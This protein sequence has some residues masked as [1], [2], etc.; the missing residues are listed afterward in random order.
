M[1][2]PAIQ[3]ERHRAS[4]I[5]LLRNT[6]LRDVLRGRLT[7][8]LNVEAVLA[9]AS[10]PDSLRSLAR[11]VVR[12]T[13]LWRLEKVDVARELVAHF[14]DGIDAGRSLKN[15]SES[16][17]D[18][19][20]AARLIR[21]AKKRQRPFPV[22]ALALAAQTVCAVLIMLPVTYA[23]LAVY[24]HSGSPRIARNFT[25]VWNAAA[26]ATPESDRA[27]PI[28]RQAALATS[29]WPRDYRKAD[30]KPDEP[31]WAEMEA[32]LLA[33]QR[34]VDLYR[35]AAAKPV[36]G[37]VFSDAPDI[38]LQQRYGRH[39]LQGSSTSD[40][41]PSENPRVF[42]V[43][44]PQTVILREAAGLIGLDTYRAVPEEDGQRVAS[45]IAAV[46]GMSEHS[47]Q[48]EFVIGD[49]VAMILVGKAVDLLDY[50]LER[51][52]SLLND[53]QLASLS[54]QFSA[55]RGGG[56]FRLNLTRERAGFQDIIQRVYTDDGKGDGHLS[57]GGT[58]L[59]GVSGGSAVSDFS[60]VGF[61]FALPVAGALLAGRA[62]IIEKYDEVF[63]AVE[64]D[65]HLPLWQRGESRAD[66]MLEQLCR[67]YV[68]MVR[69]MPVAMLTPSLFRASLM[70][71]LATQ[72]RDAILV[73]IALEL[74]HRRTGSWPERLEQ[75]TPGLLPAVP[76]DR[77]NGSAL[78]YRLADG[79][80]VVYSVGPDR[81]DDGGRDI[82]EMSPAA[83]GNWRRDLGE[84]ILSGAVESPD[85]DW[86]LWS[87]TQ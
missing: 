22:K 11:R 39:G 72:R 51:N 55:M 81:D 14:C 10:L 25:A 35:Q 58:L 33:N 64:A 34:A 16:F 49:L 60:G 9:R 40:S 15:L 76:P 3:P 84:D 2:T 57:P 4:L 65:D 38:P 45:N 44:L 8:R 46:L 13:R 75:L 12:R 23:G 50:V 43:L 17:G 69:Y 87:A 74:H 42:N 28:Y 41:T 29:K 21:R 53:S 56:P 59:A 6:P 19:V 36:L 1:T 26:L 77:F 48:T 5:S 52:P 63:A 66:R 82:S 24:L 18:P 47:S 54:H 31:A 71:E 32:F 20:Q 67:S 37:A 27:W 86:V 78:R 73:A 70:M 83:G 62:D 79:V 61:G 68:G 30:V 80:P 85:G 7:G